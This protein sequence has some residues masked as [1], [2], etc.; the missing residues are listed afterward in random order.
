MH[1]KFNFFYQKKN[2]INYSFIKLKLIFI[3][4]FIKMPER[5]LVRACAGNYVSECDKCGHSH[6]QY[7]T[8]QC[9]MCQMKERLRS[10]LP[11]DVF[12]MFDRL[13]IL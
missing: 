13:K 1:N 7:D 3:I 4:N 2:I 12:E 9:E 5:S 11:V 10:T 8:E 6:S